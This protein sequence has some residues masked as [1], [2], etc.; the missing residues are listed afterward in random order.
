MFQSTRRSASARSLSLLVS[1]Q[2]LH[3]YTCFS[4]FFALLGARTARRE[5]SCWESMGRVR[6]ARTDFLSRERRGV[7]CGN[8]K[9]DR[10]SREGSRGPEKARAR[11]RL[12]HGGCMC[13][14]G[15]PQPYSLALLTVHCGPASQSGRRR[16]RLAV[17]S[18]SGLRG[19]RGISVCASPST[20]RS[21]LFAATY[22]PSHFIVLPP[23]SHT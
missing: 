20:S 4:R 1:L 5:G 7:I 17:F 3:F 23:N 11:M 22:P 15:Y 14:L 2:S 18:V 9:A 10:R 13:T 21:I 6:I 19:I 16:V 12:A 8:A